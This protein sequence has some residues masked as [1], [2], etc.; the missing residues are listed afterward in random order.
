MELDEYHF[1]TDKMDPE[2]LDTLHALFRSKSKVT[3]ST[4]SQL[5]AESLGR[6]LDAQNERR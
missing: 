5:A 4:L 6:K 1:Y 3:E 2:A